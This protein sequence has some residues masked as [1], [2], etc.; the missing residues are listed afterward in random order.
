MKI[1]TS[2]IFVK[3]N[4]KIK[5]EINSLKEEKNNLISS[6]EYILNNLVEYKEFLNTYSTTSF[7]QLQNLTN[8]YYSRSLLK[9]RY[10]GIENLTQIEN[11]VKRQVNVIIEIKRQTLKIEERLQE[12]QNQ[13]ISSSD[14][15]SILSTFNLSV[16]S[17]ILKGY[18]FNIG[19][20][21]SHIRIKRKDV[22]TRKHKKIDWGESNKKKKEILNNNK[23]PYEVLERTEDGK[24]SIDNKG[25]H[26]LIY[27]TKQI[28]FLWHWAK[29]E[30]P[31]QNKFFYKFKPTYCG[32]NQNGCVQKL[33]QIEKQNSDNLKYF[34]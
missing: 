24:I 34:Y 13:I 25:E 23:L 27:H 30:Y 3:Y 32:A 29:G 26:W 14:F 8:A 12:L 18:V 15:I 22:S 19:Y 4:K 2:E 17:E 11:K 16:V 10:E 21:L 1:N 5:I 33:R 31:I 9:K 7:E 28:E 20:G 6:K